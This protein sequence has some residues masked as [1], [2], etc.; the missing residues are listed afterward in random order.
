MMIY[1]RCSVFK[2]G[3]FSKTGSTI[4]AERLNE[5]PLHAERTPIN[6]RLVN[7]LGSCRVVD[8]RLEQPGLAEDERPAADAQQPRAPVHR[9]PQLGQERLGVLARAEPGLADRGQRDQVGLSQPL[10]PEPGLDGEVV[11]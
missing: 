11:A 3:P 4:L 7:L 9:R 10:Q 8:L 1:L 6:P 5:S 2:T